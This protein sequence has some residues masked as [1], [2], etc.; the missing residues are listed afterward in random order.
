[1]GA[2]KTIVHKHHKDVYLHIINNSAIGTGNIP[3]IYPITSS[4]EGFLKYSSLDLDLQQYVEQEY[5][6]VLVDV[7]VY[8]G[9]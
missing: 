9:K 8:D 3:M 4:M 1:M 6:M 5:E 2:F 7:T